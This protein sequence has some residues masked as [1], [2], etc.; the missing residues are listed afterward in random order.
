MYTLSNMATCKTYKNIIA[1]LF[2]IEWTQHRRPLKDEWINKW[3]IS[4]Q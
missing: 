3:D 4:R 1:A 2:I